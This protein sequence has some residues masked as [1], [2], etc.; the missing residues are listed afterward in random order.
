MLFDA[1]WRAQLL[2]AA[3]ALTACGPRR[4]QPLETSLPDAVVPVAAQSPAEIL[5]QGAASLDPSLRAR[6]VALLVRASSEAG[7]GAWGARGLADPDAWVQR[8]TVEAL[9]S[10]LPEDQSGELLLGFVE[11]DWGDPYVRGMAALHLGDGQADQVSMAWHSETQAWRVAPLALAAA[12]LG[13]TDALEPLARAISTGDLGLEVE[14]VLD[15]GASGLDAL[16]PALR[17][18]TSWV[19]DELV[20]PY[21]VAMIRL[22][23]RSG[24]GILRR[25]V[26]DPDPQVQLE[27]LDYLTRMD[28]PC[29]D[30]LL[31]RARAQGVDVVRWYADLALLG[32][33]HGDADLL[34]AAAEHED[35]EVRELAMRFAAEA[36]SVTPGEARLARQ[37]LGVGLSDM[38]PT[39]RAVAIEGLSSLGLHGETRRVEALLVDED[40]SVRAAAAGALLLDGS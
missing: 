6:S 19:E 20:L 24:E 14:F 12:A 18:G 40:P 15:L 26:L 39:V 22:G 7:G 27:A 37:V 33:G 29:A 1:P 36:G 28:Q 13:D 17:E 9:V 2:T 21:A 34:V 31:R 38:D 3:L 8:A 16:L 4:V 10:R 30:A 23:D 32:R 11:R 5:E 25:A 35:R